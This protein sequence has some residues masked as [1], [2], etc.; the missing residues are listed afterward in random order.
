[1][2][3]Q[4]NIDGGAEVPA[5]QV[6][7][8]VAAMRACVAAVLEPY[9]AHVGYAEWQVAYIC[10]RD[11]RSG[12][13]IE[14]ISYR[15]VISGGVHDVDSV[16]AENLEYELL[17]ALHWLA[18]S[19]GND[20]LSGTGAQFHYAGS[21]S[22]ADEEALAAIPAAIAEHEA[23]VADHA[24]IEANYDEAAQSDPWTNPPEDPGVE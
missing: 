7:S 5:D 15:L 9:G 24:D 18:T 19:T 23:A 2:S 11:E 16:T 1:M 3:F 12:I 21:H 13:E 14:N 22:F 20:V 8:Y 4:I 6:E 10:R 17:Q